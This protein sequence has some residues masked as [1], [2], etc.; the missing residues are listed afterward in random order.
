MTD[1]S[2]K[3]MTRPVCCH[4][5]RK[6]MFYVGDDRHTPE[7]RIEVRGDSTAEFYAH[8]AC[9]RRLLTYGVPTVFQP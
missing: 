9:W 2:T 4:F 8:E 5:C 1:T 6:A 7:V 3:A